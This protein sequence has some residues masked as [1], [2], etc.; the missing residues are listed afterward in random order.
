[1]TKGLQPF[2][3]FRILRHVYHSVIFSLDPAGRR[4]PDIPCSWSVGFR[5]CTKT[6]LCCRCKHEQ[7]LW[8]PPLENRKRGLSRVSCPVFPLENRKRVPGFP[9]SSQRH[10]L[11]DDSNPARPALLARRG[12]EIRM[13]K[14]KI[15]PEM[16]MKIKGGNVFSSTDIPVLC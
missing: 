12:T 4:A 9:Y 13:L 8:A 1:M 7:Q 6:S 2:H 15:A 3:S 10:G 14:M 5:W 16:C 11:R